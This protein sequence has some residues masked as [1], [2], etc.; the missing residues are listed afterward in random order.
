MPT[1]S[2][3]APARGTV[4]TTFSLIV[5]MFRL[6]LLS[7]E[8]YPH[9]IGQ[10]HRSKSLKKRIG[11]RLQSTRRHAPLR[12]HSTIR[13]RH[14]A[15]AANLSGLT[16]AEHGT[17]SVDLTSAFDEVASHAV[18]FFNSLVSI[19][20]SSRRGAHYFSFHGG[21]AVQRFLLPIFI[22]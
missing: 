11:A 21:S 10:P 13:R 5:Y 9:V 18:I 19:F 6:E 2:R 14:D 8:D 15:A 22:K 16:A 4:C 17:V 12:Y 3:A 7:L 1:S 20:F